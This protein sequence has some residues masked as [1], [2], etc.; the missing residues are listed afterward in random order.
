MHSFTASLINEL[1]KIAL[2]RKTVLFL[3]LTALLP[4]TV[5]IL[6]KYAKSSLGFHLFGGSGFFLM[7][8]N[9]MTAIVLPVIIFMQAA[10]SF[11]GEAGDRSLKIPL[12]RPVSRWNLFGSKQ[13]ALII[14]I[15]IFLAAAGLGA[16]L[17]ALIF[18]IGGFNPQALAEALLAYTAALLPMTALSTASVWISQWFKSG[19]GAMVIMLLLYIGFKAASLFFADAASYTPAGYTDWH[20]LWL[21]GAGWDTLGNIFLFLTG[22]SIV[23]YIAGLFQF[24]RKAL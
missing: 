22:C 4:S 15:A 21:G 23:C 1:E 16:M 13:L 8:L 10:D 19:S 14:W 3:V 24:D 7:V 17:A 12:M 2:R 11:A 20:M 6:A 18:G 5:A 9:L